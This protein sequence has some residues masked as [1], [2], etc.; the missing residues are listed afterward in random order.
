LNGG[1]AKNK[2]IYIHFIA[3]FHLLKNGRPMT[4]FGNLKDLFEFLKFANALKKH[5]IYSNG[6]GMAKA[7]HNMVFIKMKM[8]L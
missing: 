5:W 1:R 6:W 4:N 3:I 2:Y 7:M 8:V